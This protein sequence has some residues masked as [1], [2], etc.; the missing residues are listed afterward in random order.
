MAM[1]AG[2]TL[3]EH[4]ASGTV[5][6]QVLRGEVTF[7]AGEET[8][9]LHAGQ[10]IAFAPGVRHRAEAHEEAPLLLTISDQA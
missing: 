9:R 1:E 10:L 5:T 7:G 2:N 8:H 3:D 4:S 6:V